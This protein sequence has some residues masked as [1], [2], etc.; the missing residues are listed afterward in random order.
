MADHVVVAL[1]EDHL[2][3]LQATLANL[4]GRV[5]EVAAV[6]VRSIED[7]GKVL[8]CGNGGSAADAQHL[9]AEFDGRFLR[10]RR[11]L[12]ALALTTNTSSVTAIGNDYGF[13]RIFARGVEAHGRRGDVL[14]C[15]S[16]SGE[17]ANIS[18]AAQVGSK[19]GLVVV[20][21][22]GEGGGKL[23]SVC[24]HLLA[25]PS[26]STP[27]IQEMHIL[28]GHVVCQLVEDYFVNP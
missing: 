20:G 23:A 28:I 11:P 7:G 19:M 21:L 15:I 3:V 1:F 25:V 17:S 18:A 8:F 27:R 22:T 9:A 10:D 14:V 26:R 24:D 13:D 6:I 2:N 4:S 16:T 5:D 12:P